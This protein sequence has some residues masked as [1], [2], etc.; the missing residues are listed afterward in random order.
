MGISAGSETNET[1]LKTALLHDFAARGSAPKAMLS[2]PESAESR[3]RD[4]DMGDEPG[5]RPLPRTLSSAAD[6]GA[7][8]PLSPE[9]AATPR[10]SPWVKASSVQR[11]AGTLGMGRK[12]TLSPERTLSHETP[13]PIRSD[14]PDSGLSGDD[15]LQILVAQD[16]V[17]FS[18]LVTQPFHR[19]TRTIQNRLSVGLSPGGCFAAERKLDSAGCR[20]DLSSCCS[21]SGVILFCNRFPLSARIPKLCNTYSWVKAGCRFRGSAWDA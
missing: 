12:K 6:I 7:E 18:H 10:S 21:Q 2:M 4:L 20:R 14:Q 17:E 5:C 3:R 1:D 19:L 13:P 8:V 16:S 9:R 15:P 11:D